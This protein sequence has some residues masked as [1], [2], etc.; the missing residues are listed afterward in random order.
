MHRNRGA[1]VDN[2]CRMCVHVINRFASR[3]SNFLRIHRGINLSR[4]ECNYSYSVMFVR[5][6]FAFR[7]QTSV[8]VRWTFIKKIN[9]YSK[10]RSYRGTRTQGVERAKFNKLRKRRVQCEQ[11]EFDLHRT[12]ALSF[13]FVTTA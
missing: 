2:K 10:N 9:F 8:L 7:E 4:Y 1:L 12:A 6:F 11:T 13:A 5:R 3:K